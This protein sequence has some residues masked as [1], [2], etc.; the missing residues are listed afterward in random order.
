MTMT[1]VDLLA[2]I[3]ALDAQQV[4]VVIADHPY[5]RSADPEQLQIYNRNADTRTVGRY[6]AYSY[7]MS[8]P[9]TLSG[10]RVWYRADAIDGFQAD[11]LLE[12]GA[13][14]EPGTFIEQ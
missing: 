10:F 5:A 3:S 4:E 13:T 2:S 6:V 11:R 7:R 9:V 12:A 1:E 14:L 8:D